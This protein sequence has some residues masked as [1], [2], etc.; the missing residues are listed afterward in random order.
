MANRALTRRSFTL[1][2]LAVGL[3][4][5]K[6]ARAN[7][8]DWPQSTVT[9]IVPFPAGAATDITGRVVAAKLS[10]MWSQPV[11]VDN[12]GGGNGISAAEAAARA[13]PNGLTLFL[14]SAMTQA[15][16]PAMYD[17]LPYDPVKDFEP[18]TRLVGGPFVV[19]VPT[20]SP[21]KTLAQLTAVL[22]AEPGKHN[23]GAGALPARVAAELYR[24]LA[25]VDVVSIAYK[26]NPQA[27]SDLFSGRLTFMAIDMVNAK[28]QIDGGKMRGLAVSFAQRQA[29]LPDVL[30]SDEAGLPGFELTTWNGFYAPRGTPASLVDKINRDI[31]LACQD[32]VLLRS[33][34]SMGGH[35]KTTTPQEFKEFTASEIKKWG[36]IIARSNIKLD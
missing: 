21:I 10:K 20:T 31:I 7:E 16:N 17:K 26:S 15:V 13:K 33:F 36:S 9:I 25:G 3:G 8:K 6:L 11:V 32:P 23:F 30:S 4:I 35:P 28:L 5:S 27:F 29:E 14:T 1:G 34:D 18:I 2:A 12:R 24:Q 22:K 19:L